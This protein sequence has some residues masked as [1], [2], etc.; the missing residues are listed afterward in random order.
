LDEVFT[1]DLYASEIVDASILVRIFADT[2]SGNEA[3]GSEEIKNI[4]VSENARRAYGLYPE[5]SIIVHSIISR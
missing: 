4:Y 2:A 3:A 1:D 5:I